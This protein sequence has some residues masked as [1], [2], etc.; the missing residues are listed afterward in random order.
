[1]SAVT[2]TTTTATNVA[3]HLGLGLDRRL[4]VAVVGL[5]GRGG[6]YSRLIGT[7]LADVAE[8]VQVAEPRPYHRDA[9]AGE[10]GL[11]DADVFE[12]W[13][14]LV[15]GPRLADA[16]VI[17][18]QDRDHLR[19]IEAF[20]AAGYDILCE[21]PL[22]GTEADCA[23]AVAA[24][25]DAG[26]FLGVCHVLRY[27]PNT[28]RIIELVRSGAIGDIVA[29]QHLE[30][31]GWFHF[32]HSFVRGPW[33]NADE[34][35]P[36]L[37]T[38]SCHDL[39]W[40]SLVAGQPAV[41]VSSFGSLTG[42]T[43][44]NKPQGATDRCVTCP[45]EPDCAYSAVRMYRA[46][47]EPGRDET[48]F[49]RIAAPAFTAEAVDEALRSGPYG[50]CV[51]DCDNDVVDHQVVNIEYANGATASFTLAAFTRFENRRT[52]IF[53]TRGQ[54]V[55]DGRTVELYDFTR[56]EATADDLAGDG[57]GHGGG[58]AAMLTAFVGALHAGEPDRFVSNGDESLATHRIV[59]AAERARLTNTVVSL[60]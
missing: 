19:A 10:L 13:E 36:L 28:Q 8:V 15:A 34:S 17:T 59:F 22:A 42:F 44:A 57:T 6:I 37:L 45:V 49:T 29:I 26:V 12:R 32:A 41:R 53:G 1:V 27:T 50:R 33:R 56:R 20:A 11:G 9:V 51:Y 3:A 39:D 14:D 60:Q 7:G 25:D 43:Q 5:G 23:A 58:D 47:L 55:S 40:L 35:G 48:Y 46:G 21:K 24:A 52:S 4:R 31:V 38:K 2:T 16:V 30:P 54:I 18:T